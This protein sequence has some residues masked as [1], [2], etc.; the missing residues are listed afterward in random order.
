MPGDLL[1]KIFGNWRV[2]GFDIYDSYGI[3]R[4]KCECA[5]GSKCSVN[6]YHLVSGASTQ[7]RSCG[8]TNPAHIIPG[9]FW[10][11]LRYQA[12]HRGFV[13]EITKDYAHSVWLAQEGKCALTGWDISLPD[14]HKDWKYYKEKWTASMDRINC[15]VGYVANNI[16]WV[17]KIVNMVRSN[18]PV[19]E[20]IEWCDRIA[21]YGEK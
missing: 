6:Q 14:G 19:P 11:H 9:Q 15:G 13:F 12:K 17:H 4:W 7:C 18:L 20:F 10:A 5:C 3:P 2:L 8:S 16:Q 1:G 21:T